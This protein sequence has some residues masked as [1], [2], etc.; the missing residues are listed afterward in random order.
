GQYTLDGI[1]HDAWKRQYVMQVNQ[2]IFRWG[3]RAGQLTQDSH[4]FLTHVPAAMF[5]NQRTL[6]DQHTHDFFHEERIPFGTALDSVIENFGQIMRAEQASD[7]FFAFLFG[8][9]IKDDGCE[10]TPSSS[11]IAPAFIKIRASG[12]E[13][14]HRLVCDTV[15]KIFK[16]I[17]QCLIRPLQIINNQDEWLLLRYCFEQDTP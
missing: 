15:S 7:E 17:E 6:V 11:P 1:G 12:A 2:R 16:Q 13:E 8:K 14:K 4:I 5:V 10:I 3:G 9:G